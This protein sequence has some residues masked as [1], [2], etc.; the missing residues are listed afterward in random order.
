[1]LSNAR[2]RPWA[3]ALLVLAGCGKS[4]QGLVDSTASAQASRAGAMPVATVRVHARG[5]FAGLPDRGE[6]LAY[7]G[8]EV[9][10]D[11][12]YT[13]HRTGLSEAYALRA[14]ADGHLRVTTPS[15][16]LLDFKY[17]RHIEHPSGD[18]TWIGHLRQ[19]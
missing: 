5:A 7:P 9:R 12:A 11:G 18:W 10:R 17:D 2:Y 14:I 4:P 1:M 6:L 19:P 3:L 8:H 16:Q 15:G 13:W